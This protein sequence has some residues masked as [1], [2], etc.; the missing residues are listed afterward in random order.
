[1]PVG[2][3]AT[4]KHK[5]PAIRVLTVLERRTAGLANI[6][7]LLINNGRFDDCLDAQFGLVT[8]TFSLG[9]QFQSQLFAR[10]SSK[11]E[12]VFPSRKKRNPSE[13]DLVTKQR[14]T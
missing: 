13:F 1:M 4:S 11:M 6:L 3:V 14:A 10:H 2:G 12:Y 9:M 8:V 5:D 7:P